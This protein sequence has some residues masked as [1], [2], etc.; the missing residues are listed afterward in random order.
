[1]FTNDE[2]KK[3]R[4]RNL[5]DIM[6]VFVRVAKNKP[7]RRDT[8]NATLE[9]RNLNRIFDFLW[10]L[11]DLNEYP[12]PTSYYLNF[13]HEPVEVFYEPSGGGGGITF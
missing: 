6:P 10:R 13:A 12:H 8:L 1:M 4:K 2:E 5:S 7:L 3:S 11:N 9:T